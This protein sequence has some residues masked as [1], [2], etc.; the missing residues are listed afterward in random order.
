M[1]SSARFQSACALLLL[2]CAAQADASSISA[3]GCE[4][5]C[6]GAFCF[7]VKNKI[8]ACSTFAS[9]NGQS[10]S[11]LEPA[12]NDQAKAAGVSVKNCKG[13][14]VSNGRS[15]FRLN[16]FLPNKR[17]FRDNEETPIATILNDDLPGILVDDI[18]LSRSL[19]REL[20][21]S[22]VSDDM[23][24]HRRN[25][26]A[27]AS[28]AVQLTELYQP[29]MANRRLEKCSGGVECKKPGQD[30]AFGN[31]DRCTRGYCCKAHCFLGCGKCEAC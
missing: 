18:G 20:S 10:C 22:L 31:V 23:F 27:K 16:Y 30:C 3:C 12:I 8:P 5:E 11:A 1:I 24:V 13:T 6:S 29:P 26:D 19:A 17:N 28:G 2:V 7:I 21:R 9:Y 14:V 15:L 25:L 4:C